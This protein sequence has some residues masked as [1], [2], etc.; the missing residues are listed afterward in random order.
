MTAAGLLVVGSP[1]FDTPVNNAGAVFLFTINAT[2]ET[3]ELR[4]TITLVDGTICYLLGRVGGRW[5]MGRVGRRWE[6]GRALDWD[7]MFSRPRVSFE[8]FFFSCVCPNK[9]SSY[10]RPYLPF[11][12][13]V[14]GESLGRIAAAAGDLVMSSAKVP[15]R[16]LLLYTAA[17][18]TGVLTVNAAFCAAHGLTAFDGRCI[19]AALAEVD[20]F[21]GAYIAVTIEPGTECTSR[22]V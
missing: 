1:Q 7:C 4:S 20:A 13:A 10:S 14:G 16:E 18:A 22:V 5:E 17:P 3:V 12:T 19:S 2:A 11:N 9:P 8:S 15:G 21:P 6:M